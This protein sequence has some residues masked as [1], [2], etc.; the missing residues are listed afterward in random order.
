MESGL[1]S[2]LSLR[3]ADVR[4][5]ADTLFLHLFGSCKAL[6]EWRKKEVL[7]V[8]STW[9]NT[10]PEIGLPTIGRWID[11]ERNRRCYACDVM[12]KMQ[13]GAEATIPSLLERKCIRSASEITDSMA[14]I[15]PTVPPRRRW[16]PKR[17]QRH[18]ERIQNTAPAIAL[19]LCSLL[20]NA[21]ANR[22]SLSQVKSISPFP[23]SAIYSQ[24]SSSLCSATGSCFVLSLSFSLSFSFSS[25]GLP[26][27]RLVAP[28]TRS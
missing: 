23:T 19:P 10:A 1:A 5:C 28:L 3:G 8:S 15:Q 25:F 7:R 20:L 17:R 13:T 6:A 12:R 9:D 26:G 18:R 22:A 21:T 16:L 11:N 4:A 24:S 2:L 27:V 14:K